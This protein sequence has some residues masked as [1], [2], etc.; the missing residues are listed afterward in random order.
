MYG[1]MP[2]QYNPQEA[3]YRQQMQ[4]I[5]QPMPPYMPQPQPQHIPQQP[6]FITR[7]VTNIE[8]AKAAMIDPLSTNLFT[9]FANSKIYVKKINN[10]GLAEFYSFTLDNQQQPQ[11]DPNA[12][13]YERLERI[14]N[15]LK[16]GIND[17]KPNDSTNG[18]AKPTSVSKSTG[19]ATGKE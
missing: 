4:A 12:G 10:N 11:T 2:P 1:Q 9:D 13:I 8:E 17:V 19:N 14:E 7:P 5:A 6:Q 15:M 3:F 16:G 18:T